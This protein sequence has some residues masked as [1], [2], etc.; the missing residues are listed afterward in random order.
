M[1]S[2]LNFLYG[3]LKISYHMTLFVTF[4]FRNTFKN[5]Y[6]RISKQYSYSLG[7]S[8]QLPLDVV[9]MSTETI[10][11]VSDMIEWLNDAEILLHHQ[12][13]LLEKT[14]NMYI[15]SGFL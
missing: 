12:Y 13:P 8:K 6:E 14:S 1:I 4:I 5:I 9:T 15:F 3:F 10:P 2:L 7:V 11:A